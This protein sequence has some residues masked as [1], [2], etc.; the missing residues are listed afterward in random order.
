RGGQAVIA[1]QH[2]ATPHFDWLAV[3]PP[4][5]L[6]GA[7]IVIVLGRALI[8]H[9]PRVRQASLLT[10]VAGVAL[11]SLFVAFQW[12]FVHGDGP[13][14]A[15]A[16]TIAI[17]GFAVS[18][19][20]IVLAATLLALLISAGYLHREK[21]E[22]PEYLVLML[23]SA[24]GMLLMVTANDLITVFLSLEILSIAL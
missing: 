2:L 14:Q 22:T 8:R 11:A 15:I 4:L 24:T 17:D 7:A 10:A 5:S 18:A 20:S 13:Y 19:Q 9:D 6:F 23:C 16:G 3:A 12:G 1:A 21:L